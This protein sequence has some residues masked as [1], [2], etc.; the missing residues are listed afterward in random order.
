MSTPTAAEVRWAQRV[1][2]RSEADLP[3]RDDEV[4]LLREVLARW[5]QAESQPQAGRKS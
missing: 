4:D 1:L 2:A 3:V 5:K